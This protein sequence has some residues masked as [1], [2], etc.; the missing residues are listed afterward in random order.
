MGL[1]CDWML[2]GCRGNSVWCLNTLYLEEGKIR[3]RL[4]LSF[5]RKEQDRG[6]SG[7]FCG[8]LDNVG[9]FSVFRHAYGFVFVL[10]HHGHKAALS[11]SDLCGIGYVQQRTSGTRWQC[12]ASCWMLA[13][14]SSF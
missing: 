3:Q 6:M 1:C 7:Y 12:Q 9:V 14:A 8:V 2:S 11:E 10:T 13:V 5:V 4:K